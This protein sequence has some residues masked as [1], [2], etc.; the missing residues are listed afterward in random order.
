LPNNDGS[1][2]KNATIYRDY[3]PL[4]GFSGYDIPSSY[5]FAIVKYASTVLASKPNLDP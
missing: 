3:K 1:E 2:L 4:T 5:L